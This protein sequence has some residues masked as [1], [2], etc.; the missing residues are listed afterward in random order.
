MNSDDLTTTICTSVIA[1]CL[2]IFFMTVASCE[3]S[4]MRMNTQYLTECLKAGKSAVH[5]ECLPIGKDD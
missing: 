2:L 4:R 3:E 5:G 1:L